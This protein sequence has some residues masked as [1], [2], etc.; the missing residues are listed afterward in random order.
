MKTQRTDPL[1]RASRSLIANPRAVDLPSS[2]SNPVMLD[3]IKL[4]RATV[5]AGLAVLGFHL[6]FMATSLSFCIILF[7]YSLYSLRRVETSRKAFYAGLLVG[8]AIYAPQLSFFWNIFG[9]AALALWLVLAF[10]VG[11]FV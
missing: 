9:P 11:L 10:W 8:F 6:A 2:M 1:L 7:L 5:T 3:S 4:R